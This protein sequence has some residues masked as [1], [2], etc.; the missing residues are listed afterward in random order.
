METKT[1]W[2]LI[3]VGL[4]I[5]SLSSI[6]VFY[7][8][9]YG[10]WIL[11]IVAASVVIG[12]PVFRLFK[13]RR[14]AVAIAT[15]LALFGICSIAFFLGQKIEKSAEEKVQTVMAN[16]RL[17]HQQNGRPPKSIDELIPRYLPADFDRRY[18]GSGLRYGI[19][20]FKNYDDTC[21]FRYSFPLGDKKVIC[22]KWSNERIVF[23]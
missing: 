14:I 23:D 2:M 7:I 16:I 5:A 3:V 22:E 19:G 11:P 15:M 21:L 8:A 13:Q 9:A 1:P 17:F 4:G 18:I 20:Y 12:I 10:A 6:T